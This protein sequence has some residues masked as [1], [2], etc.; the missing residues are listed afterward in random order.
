MFYHTTT[1]D[2]LDKILSGDK[3]LYTLK[4]L[5][6]KSPETVIAVENEYNSTDRKKDAVKK[7]YDEAVA[8]GKQTDAVFFTKDRYLPSYG[9]VLIAKDFKPRAVSENK[10][11][12]TIPDEYL[13]KNKYVSLRNAVIYVPHKIVDALRSKYP[14]VNIQ[15]YDEDSAPAQQVTA[16]DRLLAAIVHVPK[17]FKDASGEQEVEELLSKYKKALLVGSAGLG[18]SN[19]TSDHDI[20]IPTNT[21]LGRKRLKNQLAK[22]YQ[23]LYVSRDDEK[24]TTFSGDIN[25]NEFNIALIPRQYADPFI[26]G[27]I[28]AKAYLDEHE[29]ER[30]R[31]KFIKRMLEKLPVRFPYKA[32]K[33]YVDRDLGITKNYI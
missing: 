14:K 17:L 32:Y 20:I 28:N 33:K 5:A 1:T 29:S 18:I 6:D 22:Q 27:Y 2:T 3:R 30:R 7:L 16:V 23:D 24:K 19:D 13:R 9:D 31:I 25:G 21:E 15:G 10:R 26:G 8:N 11:Y 4:Q 12:T